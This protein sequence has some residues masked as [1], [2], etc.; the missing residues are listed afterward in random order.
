MYINVIIR[1]QSQHSCFHCL[2]GVYYCNSFLMLFS[3]RADHPALRTCV[4]EKSASRSWGHFLWETHYI[5]S[6][7]NTHDIL[8]SHGRAFFLHTQLSWWSLP[9]SLGRKSGNSALPLSDLRLLGWKTPTKNS[10]G[11]EGKTLAVQFISIGL[12]RVAADSSPFGCCYNFQNLFYVIL[13][14]RRFFQ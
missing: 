14:K 5:P 11:R 8:P 10:G 13:M 12:A 1:P 9:I 4:P 7:W 6:F 3:D 2:I